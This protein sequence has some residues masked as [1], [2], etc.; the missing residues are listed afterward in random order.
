MLMIEKKSS[1]KRC[2]IPKNKN[3]TKRMFCFL[4]MNRAWYGYGQLIHAKRPAAASNEF[5]FKK[6]EPCENDSIK[7]PR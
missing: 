3:K 2:F 5:Y 6:K 7:C 4:H 1:E